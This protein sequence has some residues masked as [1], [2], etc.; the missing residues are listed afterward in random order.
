MDQ[1]S[2]LCTAEGCGACKFDIT[3]TGAPINFVVSA[4]DF[5]VGE[6]VALTIMHTLYLSEHNRHAQMVAA[7][8]PGWTTSRSPDGAQA[9]PR[10]VSAND[11]EEYL[12]EVV[13]SLKT[14]KYTG[15]KKNTE[16]G[17]SIEFATGAFRYGHSTTAPYR[18]WTPTSRPVC[19]F[20]Q[21]GVFGKPDQDRRVAVRRAVGR[22]LH[23][24]H[25]VLHGQWWCARSANW[26]WSVNIVRGLV[27]TPVDEPDLKIN[28]VLRSIRIPGVIGNG[29][30][31]LTSDIVRGRETGLPSYYELRKEFYKGS[32][33]KDLYEARKCV[34]G[35]SNASSA[36]A[37][38]TPIPRL[39]RPC[40]ASTAKSP[41][42]MASSASWPKT[43]RMR[44]STCRERRRASSSTSTC[45]P[46][47]VTASG[48]SSR[49][50]CPRGGGPHRRSPVCRH[51]PRELPER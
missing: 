29:V 34:G 50:T 33:K 44:A 43:R 21:P 17:T 18:S 24:G 51:R 37:R 30:D 4:G 38:S 35:T 41:P 22:L 49:A 9:P 39:P 26:R 3:F 20:I 14:P 32:R 16:A 1:C 40:R 7:Q 19:F 28:D 25:R 31:L 36:S 46:A 13:R 5:R 6:N 27:N 11:V 15:Y 2:L 10:A 47:M 48:M 8:N 23:P 12:P 42:S 45:A